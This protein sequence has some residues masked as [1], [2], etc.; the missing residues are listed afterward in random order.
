MERDYI[1]TPECDGITH[2]N[3]YSKGKT[4]L[5]RMLS[6]FYYFPFKSRDGEFCSIEGYWHWLGIEECEE[7]EI[8]RILYGYKAR[9]VG[10]KLK[11]KYKRINDENFEL[12]I[13]RSIQLKIYHN[14]DMF[15]DSI[16]DLPFEHYYVYGDKIIDIRNKYEWMINGIEKIRNDINDVEKRV[17]RKV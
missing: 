13:L 3:I 12:K 2:I 16:K 7:K 9:D 4:L 17:I 14:L 15:T 11:K 6:N 5:G 10:I 8:L 1:L